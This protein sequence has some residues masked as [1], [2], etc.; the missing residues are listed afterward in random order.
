[1]RSIG[2]SQP[3]FT[4]PF[5][6]LFG[7]S[8]STISYMGANIYPEDVEQALFSDADDARRLG[9]FCL[10]L[11]DVGEAEQRPCIHVEVLDGAGAGSDD[12][13]ERRDSAAGA[14]A[15]SDGGADGAVDDPGLADRLRE[16]VLK[17]LLAANHDFRASLAEDSRAGEIQ[18]R[19]HR[20]G[21]GPFAANHGRIKRRYI[22]GSPPSPSPT[23]GGGEQTPSP[24]GRGL[25]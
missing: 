24:S 21:S 2:P 19:L 5:L 25:G 12:G 23:H 1:M 14:M 6:Y 16:R 8:D 13:G 17:R 22:V 3:A 18:V 20:A 4:L 9:A 11:I 10:E 15:G 7:R